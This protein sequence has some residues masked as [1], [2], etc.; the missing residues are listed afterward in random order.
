VRPHTET[1]LWCAARAIA[2]AVDGACVAAAHTPAGSAA[3]VRVSP[4]A[5]AAAAVATA[6]PAHHV[7][8]VAGATPASG[9]VTATAKPPDD[10]A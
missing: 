8:C 10:A 7:A 2:G 9:T 4:S 1:T 6:V 5:A 3:I